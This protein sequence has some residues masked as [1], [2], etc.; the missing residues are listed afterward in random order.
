MTVVRR[1]DRVRGPGHDDFWDW[2][3][4]GELRL[5]RCGQCGHLAWPVLATCEACGSPDLRWE[6]TSGDGT[7]A[8]WCSFERDYYA[9]LLPIPW[10]TILVELAE[11]PLFI[12]NPLGFDRHD[13]QAGMAL[14]LCFLDCEDSAGRFSL[15]VFARAG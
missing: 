8:S 1:P 3:G 2:C 7:L 6:R 14:K 13:Y 10:E 11:G 5:Q 9:R 4:K 12:S 15:P